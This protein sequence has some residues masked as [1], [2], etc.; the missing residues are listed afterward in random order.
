MLNGSPR[1]SANPEH[2][3]WHLV[4][5]ESELE[6]EINP[7]SVAARPLIAV[8]REDC[9]RVYDA[10]CPHR[11]ANLGYGG[12]L[13]RNHVVCPFHGKGIHL[14]ERANSRLCVREHQV[15]RFGAAVFVRLS[16]KP[17]DDRGFV[18]AM[19]AITEDRQIVD[20]FTTPV[21]VPPELVTENAFDV[22]HFA[23]VHGV[24][25]VV[26]ME[27]RQGE[28]GELGIEGA[29]ETEAPPW[30]KQK[31]TMR[32]RFWARAFSP[33]VVVTELGAGTHSHVVITGAAATPEGCTARVAYGIRPENG[34]TAG[35]VLDALVDGGH[36]A[37]RQDIQVWEHLDL[38]VTPR[39][40]D[41]DEP[42]RAFQRFCTEFS[43]AG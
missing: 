32:T 34:S 10:T 14:G 18:S 12:K 1:T 38:S 2:S 4:A 17:G 35:P 28:S 8:R 43:D 16:D 30:A 31:G 39:F 3:G 40:D 5:F 22:D 24:P 36:R 26:D 25:K 27:L 29:F 20:G 19:K 13:V 23:S 7:I 37:F 41:R 33:T 6:E 42:I 21:K 9:L 15:E 11:G